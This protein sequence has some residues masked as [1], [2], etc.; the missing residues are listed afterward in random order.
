VQGALLRAWVDTRVL[1]AFEG[2]VLPVDTTVALRC[3]G[4]HVPN[5]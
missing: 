3:A 4:L 1:P 2:R 5:P